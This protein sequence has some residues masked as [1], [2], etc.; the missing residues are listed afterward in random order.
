[1]SIYFNPEKHRQYINLLLFNK[2]AL[3]KVCSKW[4]CYSEEF[5]MLSFCKQWRQ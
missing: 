4:Q 2:Y 3:S 5:E 1:M